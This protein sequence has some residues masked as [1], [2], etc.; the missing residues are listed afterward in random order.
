MT[1][2]SFQI[3]CV[4]ALSMGNYGVLMSE[5]LCAQV[6]IWS[7]PRGGL[8][9]PISTAEVSLAQEERKV[10]VIAWHPAADN[11]LAFCTQNFVKIYD[12]GTSQLKYG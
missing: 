11:I 3:G 1:V 4:L 12:V 8:A 2:S 10:E 5:I 6:K 9:G 7:L